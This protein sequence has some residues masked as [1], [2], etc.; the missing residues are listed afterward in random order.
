MDKVKEDCIGL[1]LWCLKTCKHNSFSKFQFCCLQCLIKCIGKTL[2][3][4]TPCCDLANVSYFSSSTV[5]ND[6]YNWD[7]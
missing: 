3:Y 2:S 1:L 5:V 4:L 6:T 7:Y